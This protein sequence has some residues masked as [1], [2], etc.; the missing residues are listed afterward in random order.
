LG[1]TAE[2]LAALA[3]QGSIHGE[4]RRGCGPYYKLRFRRA[5]GRQA[6][7]YLGN[8]PLLVEALREELRGLRRPREQQTKL[9]N[10]TKDARRL[11]RRSKQ[12]LTDE[13]HAVGYHFHG[14][15]IRKYRSV[16]PEGEVA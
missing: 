15:T 4:Y 5:D 9:S 16:V 12:Q 14:L 7:R 2:D 10:L 8:D 6:V 11:M 13:L 3:R 1:L